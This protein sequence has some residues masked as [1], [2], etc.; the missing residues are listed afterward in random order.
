MDNQDILQRIQTLVQEEHDL[1]EQPQDAGDGE[2]HQSHAARLRKVEE[3]LDQ[4]WDLLRQRRAKADAGENPADADARPIS[5]VE[6][7]RQ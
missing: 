2:A 7:Y 6:G 3:D 1:R 4:C 5:Q